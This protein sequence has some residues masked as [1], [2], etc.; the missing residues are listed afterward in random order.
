MTASEP[1]AEPAPSAADATT[2]TAGPIPVPSTP[3]STESDL[4]NTISKFGGLNVASGSQTHP[5]G[6]SMSEEEYEAM[7]NEGSSNPAPD[8]DAVMED[9]GAAA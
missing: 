8:G 5:D 4:G 9:A 2:A 3:T 6:P 1:V 7:L